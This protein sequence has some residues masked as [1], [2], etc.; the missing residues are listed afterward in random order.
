M[1]NFWMAMLMLSTLVA[2]SPPRPAVSNVSAAP[3]LGT[4]LFITL[5][6]PVAAT[7]DP[8]RV[9]ATL[10][11]ENGN[12]PSGPK[13]ELY[14]R[15]PVPGARWEALG[16]VEVTNGFYSFSVRRS[17]AAEFQVRFRGIPGILRASTSPTVRLDIIAETDVIGAVG[18]PRTGVVEGSRITLTARTSR[19]LVGKRVS[20][21][22]ARSATV[23]KEVAVGRVAT[24]GRMDTSF[25]PALGLRKYR[26]AVQGTPELR[27]T[28]TGDIN[29]RTVPR[30]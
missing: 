4:R 24:D 14:Q 13:V 10:I 27:G 19:R 2:V 3:D 16:A 1:R 29:V 5:E 28:Y 8:V 22:L 20:V 17:T 9:N 15:R 18:V 23:W 21:Q 25:A 6:R 30:A 12:A 11:L 7:Q 26:L